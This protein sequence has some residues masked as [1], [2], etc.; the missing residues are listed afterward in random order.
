MPKLVMIA[1]GFPPE[2]N[3]GAY[4]PL[5]FLR[6]L[7]SFGWNPAVIT[8]IPSQYERYDSTLS[9][10][11]PK[12]TEVIRIK[13]SDV[14]QRFQSWRA[15][16]I[17]GGG[18]SSRPAPVSGT[19][20]YEDP[21]LFRARLRE[22][23]RL[24]EAWWYHPDMASP[25]INAAAAAVTRV[26]QRARVSVIWA[27][28]G[29]VSALYAARKAS[30]KTGVPYVLD[31]RDSWT[32]THNDFESRRPSWAIRRDR[33]KMFELLHDAQAV[34]FRY[35]TEAECFVR[36]YCGALD[37]SKVYI[38]PNGYE[39]PI[40]ESVAPTGDR[41]TILYAGVVGDYRYD[42]FL[43][44]LTLL[45]TRDPGQARQLQVLFVGEGMEAL[46]KE[47]AVLGLSDIVETRGAQPYAEVVRLQQ[48]A[49]ALLVF[50]RPST[51]EG[52][53]L[54]AGA[55]L[56]GYL[57]AGRPIAGVLPSDETKKVLQRVGARTIADVDAVPEIVE[58]LR[59]LLEHW[60]KGTLSSLVPDPKACEVYSSEHQTEILVRALGGVPPERP[61]IPGAQP[62][63]PSLRDRLANPAW[64]DGAN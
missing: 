12:D 13:G 55:K 8:A 60:A 37:A 28:A 7:P 62:I 17:G 52:Y 35:D 56:F 48:A 5:R 16:G 47:V 39:P 22:L 1:Y 26:C 38:I 29:P 18:A 20:A 36:A 61:F 19:V 10:E 43:E 9:A 25:W 50:G 59:V 31:F 64:L 11:I 21:T 45:K 54:F 33:H 24:A 3:A 40:E 14:W 42:T 63:P 49:H 27:T 53:E 23:I 57:K 30:R 34:I 2:G 46:A 15:R 32:I 44:A 6:R 41:C 51:K 58:M 4:R